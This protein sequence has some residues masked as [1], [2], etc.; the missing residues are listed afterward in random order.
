M[1]IIPL[2]AAIAMALPAAASAQ[3]DP[4]AAAVKARQG[5]F[6][7]LGANMGTLAGMARGQ[8]DYDEAAAVRAASNIEALMGYDA[9]IHFPAGSS[10]DDLGAEVT[11]ARANIWTDMDG[12]GEKAADLGMAVEGL[13]DAVV[14]GQQNV[15]AAIGNVGAACKACHDDYR[16]K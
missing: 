5:Y 13:S 9:S 15:G 6:A 14:G 4:I 2:I 11:E 1:R 7:M 8:I 10:A 12:F 16:V 3:E